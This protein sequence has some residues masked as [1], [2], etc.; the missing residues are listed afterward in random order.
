MIAV[1]RKF[2]LG[3][4]YRDLPLRVENSVYTSRVENCKDNDKPV[5]TYTKVHVYIQSI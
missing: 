3:G 1:Y 5:L 4:L 2:P